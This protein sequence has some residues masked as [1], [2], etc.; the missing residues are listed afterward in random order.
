MINSPLFSEDI[1][2]TQEGGGGGGDSSRAEGG[3]GR[4]SEG[5]GEEP[6]ALNNEGWK[7]PGDGPMA[8][9]KRRAGGVLVVDGIK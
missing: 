8:D 3:N 5:G 9:A 7:E 6:S 4:R 1:E 2:Q